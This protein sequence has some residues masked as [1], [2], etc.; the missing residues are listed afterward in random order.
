MRLLDNG[1]IWLLLGATLACLGGA[2]TAALLWTMACLRQRPP[3]GRGGAPPGAE[4]S[5]SQEELLRGAA[6]QEGFDNLM[7]YS[8]AAARG[9][10]APTPREEL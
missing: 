7:R 1:L 3:K 6:M 4:A 2:W 5:P 10:D 8:V 9:Q